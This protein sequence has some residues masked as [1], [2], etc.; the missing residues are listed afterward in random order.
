MGNDKRNVTVLGRETEFTGT[1]EF[2][3]SLVITGKFSGTIKATG[4]LEIDR[5]AVCHADAIDANSVVVFGKVMG[6]ITAGERVELCSGS[7]VTGDLR[8]AHIRIADG[9]EF[10]G[11]VE[12]LDAPPGL[13]LFSVASK[14]FKESLLIKSDIPR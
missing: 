14:E 12:M 1:I 5:T 2:T 10:A 9:A 3:D 11:K 7:S 13:D 4:D 6:N 8:A